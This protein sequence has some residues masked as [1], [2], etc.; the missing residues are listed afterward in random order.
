M[1]TKIVSDLQTGEVV[2]VELEGEELE[3]YNQ[4]LAEQAANQSSETSQLLT[5]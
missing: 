4:L 2:E 3:A 1:P 5:Q